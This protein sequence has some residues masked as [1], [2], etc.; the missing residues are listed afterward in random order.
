MRIIG[1]SFCFLLTEKS[2]DGVSRNNI[3]VL[4]IILFKQAL[5]WVFT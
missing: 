2:L 3:E 1:R 4:H 5:L